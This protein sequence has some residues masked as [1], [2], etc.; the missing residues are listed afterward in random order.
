IMQKMSKSMQVFTITHLPQI[1]AKGDTHFKVYKEVKDNL[2]T[3]EMKK[4]GEEERIVEIAQMLGG[5]QVT[6]SAVAH[7]KQLLN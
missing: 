1:A 5:K 7:A 3:T 6:D 2:T 4:L